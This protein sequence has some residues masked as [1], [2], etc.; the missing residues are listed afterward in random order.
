MGI[1]SPNGGGDSVLEE[2]DEEWGDEIET[3]NVVIESFNQI[4]Q[5]QLSNEQDKR[6]T[7]IETAIGNTESLQT[8]AVI[9]TNMCT[10]AVVAVRDQ[11]DEI[12]NKSDL[13]FNKKLDYFSSVL[14]ILTDILRLSQDDAEHKND[15]MTKFIVDKSLKFLGI[16]GN[17]GLTKYQ[18]IL[19]LCQVGTQQELPQIKSHAKL[20]LVQKNLERMGLKNE[21][22]IVGNGEI[23]YNLYYYSKSKFIK[24]MVDQLSDIHDCINFN[25]SLVNHVELPYY[26]D[27]LINS[28]VDVSRDIE[29]IDDSI[30]TITQ[31]VVTFDKQWSAD[32][33]CRQIQGRMLEMELMSK[34]NKRDEEKEMKK[35]G[36]K[37]KNEDKKPI[38]KRKPSA[39]TLTRARAEKQ[40]QTS[41]I[42]K[43]RKERKEKKD[44]IE[45]KEKKEAKEKKEQDE[46]KRKSS[47]RSS[48]NIKANKK[49][50]ISAQGHAKLHSRSE[51][52]SICRT[53]SVNVTGRSLKVKKEKG[54][55]GKNRRLSHDHANK[56]LRK[57]T[58]DKKEK[59]FAINKINKTEKTSIVN[60]IHKIHKTDKIEKKHKDK[61]ETRDKKHKKEKIS[62][63]EKIN[64]KDKKI[65]LKRKSITANLE[66]EIP[67]TIV[68]QEKDKASSPQILI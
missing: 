23:N 56:S 16:K 3:D 9:T 51:R 24:L 50:S 22:G 8:D 57:V 43:Q 64:K 31:L 33:Q 54:K 66:L 26:A 4:K 47:R 18:R 63:R 46:V 49:S 17:L 62:K 59:K 6:T 58:K 11:S 39:Q 52:N 20:L 28:I 30:Q 14:N 15:Y 41:P 37:E 1:G 12:K 60:K 65:P 7:T 42:S 48:T 55:I 29:E 13:L 19:S 35:Q 36:E 34:S 32:E 25:E 21:N 2:K 10:S 68:K 38:K 67:K 53:S 45:K 44:K 61:K 40:I 27:E 5:V